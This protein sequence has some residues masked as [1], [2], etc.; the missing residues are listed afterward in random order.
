MSPKLQNVNTV[1]TTP[2]L[3]GLV[4]SC[5]VHDKLCQDSDLVL[6]YLPVT[7]AS[8]S[9]VITILASSI[10]AHCMLVLFSAEDAKKNRK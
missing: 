2:V 10:L 7:Q 1:R 3:T 8:L 6:L 9:E 4:K 5:M